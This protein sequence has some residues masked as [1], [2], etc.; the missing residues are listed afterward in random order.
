VS[1][2]FLLPVLPIVAMIE[3]LTWRL[4]DRII[5]NAHGVKT[6]LAQ[7]IGISNDN[8]TV[9]HN[10]VAVDK[11]K[12]N[13]PAKV[14]EIRN[15]VGLSQIDG[16]LIGLIGRVTKQKNQLGLSNAL[17]MIK[18]R[19]PDLDIRV[20]YW[21]ATDDLSYVE[22]VKA[23]TK[24][25]KLQEIVFFCGP[26]S[27][28]ASVYAACDIVVLPSL[29]EGFPNVLLE[30]MAAARPVIASDIVDNARIVNDGVNGF[31]VPPQCSETLADRILELLD[32]PE[33][34]RRAMGERGQKHVAQN[35]SIEQM[36]SAT[37]AF[38]EEMGLC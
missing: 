23:L 7:S 1:E 37:M 25:L 4:S 36:V 34:L 21:G 38:Y 6:V 26:E 3:R 35:Y 24:E 8:I 13:D 28:M 5:V 2:I 10:G 14:T 9:I 33:T 19:R 32:M 16:Y 12:R 22:V 17:H 15:K 11:F 30:A 20:A 31:L 29:W 18:S 27:E